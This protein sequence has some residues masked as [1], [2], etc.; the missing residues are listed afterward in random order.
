MMKKSLIYLLFGLLA[1]GSGLSGC[2]TAPDAARAPAAAVETTE[3]ERDPEVL[4]LLYSRIPTT[5]NPHLANGYQ[6]FEIARIVYE[7]LASYNADGALMPILAAEIPTRENGG[8]A[9][10]GRSVTWQLRQNVQWS[11][12]RPFTAKD[13]AFTYQ[14]VT[15]PQTAAATAKHYEGI[16]TV[17]AVDDHTVKITFKQPTPAWQHPFTGQNGMILPRHIFE[18]ALGDKARQSPANLQPVGTGPYRFLSSAQGKWLFAPNDRYR[19]GAPYFRMVEVQGGVAPYAAARSVLKTGEAD[20]AHNLQLEVSDLTALEAAGTGE[21]V[22]AFGSQVERIMLNPTDPNRATESGEKSSLDYPH[23]FLSDVRVRQAID[24]AINRSAIA[25]QLYGNFGKPTSQLLVAPQEYVS[26]KIDYEYS[27]EKARALLDEAGWK[28]TDGNGIRDQA[29]TEMTVTFQT[30]VNPV[31][32]QTQ[33]MIK[34]D[35]AAV[36]IDVNIQRV[37]VDDF[38]SANPAQTNSINHFYADLQ[39]Y[40]TGSDIP[41][42]TIYMSWWTCDEIATQANR[43]QKPNNARYCN[44][45]YDALWQAA[46]RELD[47]AQRVALFKTMDE[48]LAQDVAVLPIVHRALVNGIHQRIVGYAA[49]PWDVSTWNIAKWKVVEPAEALP[50]AVETQ[51]DD[52]TEP[53]TTRPQVP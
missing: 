30:A 7:P 5:L 2:S 10:D 48:L 15:Q 52:A 12:G 43:W 1:A 8:V 13:V 39:E 47:P 14:F 53:D 3:S 44:Q 6:D 20:F 32:Q 41:D 42:P 24:Y 28:D 16:E 37:R 19:D 35:L 11:D 38:F 50:E 23:P 49:T 17:E 21:L 34:A 45:A 9:A 27:P 46:S 4:R 22:T 29:D 51:A 33:A 40:A 26:T 25:A 18:N 31:R 36:G